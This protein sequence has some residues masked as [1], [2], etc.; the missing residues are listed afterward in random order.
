MH[1]RARMLD[2]AWVHVTQ[3]VLQKLNELAYELLP[4]QPYSSDLLPTDYHFKHVD[5]FLQEKC[6]HSQQEAESAFKEFTESQ[7]TNFYAAGINKLT[8][9]KAILPIIGKIVLT[10]MVPILVNKD[11]FDLKLQLC[12]YQPHKPFIY[13]IYT[14]R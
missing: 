12:L 1:A 5:S 9:N 6:F 8:Y 2:N 10:L 3:P 4:H 11:V 13:F 14:G 7:S